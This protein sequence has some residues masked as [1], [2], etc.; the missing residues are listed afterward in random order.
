MDEGLDLSKFKIPK[1]FWREHKDD[2]LEY[3]D[4][5][6]MNIVAYT[7]E[8]LQEQMETETRKTFSAERIAKMEKERER[9]AAIDTPDD[10]IKF[11]RTK[12]ERVNQYVFCRKALE[13]QEQV[14]P[15]VLRRYKTSCQSRFLEMSA[16]L[17]SYCEPEYLLQLLKMYN[18]IRSPYAQSLACI[19]CGMRGVE[20]FAPMLCIE[21]FRFM[22]EYP[23]EYYHEGPLIA[24]Q[25]LHEDGLI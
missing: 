3:A 22:E 24:L 17:F 16:I 4:V 13:M 21:Y 12:Y 2:E 15:L 10:M 1:G 23:D 25:T 6:M 7:V 14:M 11:M 8:D 20:S 19:V 9:I 5:A 18:D